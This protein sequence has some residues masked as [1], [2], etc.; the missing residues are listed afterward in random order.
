MRHLVERNR[1]LDTHILPIGTRY[2]REAGKANFPNV[3]HPD[4]YFRSSEP[5]RRLWLNFPVGLRDSRKWSRSSQFHSKHE[6][7][8]QPI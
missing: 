8:L 6:S 5:K 3:S 4:A 2:G 7:R 1:V